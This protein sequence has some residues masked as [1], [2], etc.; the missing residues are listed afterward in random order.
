[1]DQDMGQQASDWIMSVQP[2]IDTDG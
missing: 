1:M 2:T